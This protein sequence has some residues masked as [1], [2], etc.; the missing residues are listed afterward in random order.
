M[1]TWNGCITIS[2]VYSPSKHAIK[3]EQYIKFLEALGNRFIAAEDHNA[4]HTQWRSRLTSLRG[5][6]LLKQIDNMNVSTVSTGE[7]TYWPKDP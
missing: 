6:E 5:R 2:A 4:K 1:E 7:P 3:S